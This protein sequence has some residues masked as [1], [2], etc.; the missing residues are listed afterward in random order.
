MLENL[1]CFD[2]EELSWL[3]K[4]KC[5]L[6]IFRD[7]KSGMVENFMFNKLKKKIYIDEENMVY[8]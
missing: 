4:D 2:M 5:F 8:K 3:L 7:S 6:W 1:Y